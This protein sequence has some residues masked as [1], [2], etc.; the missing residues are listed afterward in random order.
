[1]LHRRCSYGAVLWIGAALIAGPATAAPDPGAEDTEIDGSEGTE[2]TDEAEP[3]A[4]EGS[5]YEMLDEPDVEGELS[6]EAGVE[7]SEQSSQPMVE[8]IPQD[9]KVRH[10]WYVGFGLGSGIGIAGIDEG[11]ALGLTSRGGVKVGSAGFVH[12]GGRLREKLSMGARLAN[13]TGGPVGGTS[14]MVEALYFPI[15]GRGL[16]LGAA[17]GPSVL[18]AVAQNNNEAR[19]NGRP[20]LGL[21]ADVGYDFWLLRRFNLGI[22]LQANAALNGSQARVFATT[23]GLQFNWY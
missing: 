2:A 18:Y 3:A 14:L 8:I 19:K 6:T 17:V 20:A 21:A 1:M 12:G 11:N 5:E 23:L 15:K 4:E 13:V 16:V 10:D 22:V 9:K 7:P